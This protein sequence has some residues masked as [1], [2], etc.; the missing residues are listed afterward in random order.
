MKPSEMAPS[1]CIVCGKPHPKGREVQK[2]WTYFSGVTPLGSMS[3]SR[4]CAEAVMA[5]VQKTGRAD[6]PTE[7]RGPCRGCGRMLIINDATRNVS[8]EAPLCDLFQATIARA[9]G[10]VERS[11]EV[12]DDQG[13]LVQQPRK[14]DA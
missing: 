5:R 1:C 14:G 6:V 12:R 8:H 7:Q 11:L 13:N 10:P 4:P 9:R 2:G 3:C